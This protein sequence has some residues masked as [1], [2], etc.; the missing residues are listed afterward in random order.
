MAVKTA[1]EKI[2]AADTTE[3]KAA[4]AKKARALEEKRSAKFLAKQNE[5]DLKLAEAV[6]LNTTQAE[7]LADLRVALEACEEKWYNEGFTDA[8]NSAEPVV[9]QAQRLGFEAGWFVALQAMGVPEDSPLRGPSQIPFSISTPAMQ[10]SPMPIDEEESVRIRQL[11]EQID[12]HV[13]LDDMEATSIP[14][15]GD[16]PSGDIPP[17]TTDQQQTETAAQINP[18][19]PMI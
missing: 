2:K 1:N 16:Q 19:N 13:E 11:V 7:E 6:S 5:M 3:K 4:A 14:R 8:K 18:T 15:V 17:P 9:S 12:A 10:N